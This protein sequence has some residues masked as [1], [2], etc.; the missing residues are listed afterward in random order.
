MDYTNIGGAVSDVDYEY[1]FC[2]SAKDR[3]RAELSAGRVSRKKAAKTLNTNGERK[4]GNE[5]LNVT[6]RREFPTCNICEASMTPRE[7]RF[8]KF[9]FCHCEDQPTVSDK[10][11]QSVRL[12][13]RGE[14]DE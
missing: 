6:L 12:K 9:Y 11:W 5:K 3:T 7:G 10:Y 4:W 13:T 2:D 8:G 14:N 1:A